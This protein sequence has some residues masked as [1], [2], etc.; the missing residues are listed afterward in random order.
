MSPTWRPE[1][2]GVLLNLNSNEGLGCPGGYRGL[3]PDYEAFLAL[4]AVSL[5]MPGSTTIPEALDPLKLGHVGSS[6]RLCIFRYVLNKTK[7]GLTT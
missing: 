3:L 6:P 1:L 4:H 5:L 2:T 7:Q